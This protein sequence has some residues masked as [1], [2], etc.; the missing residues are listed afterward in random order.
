M[1][2]GAK[3]QANIVGWIKTVMKACKL[4]WSVISD[5]WNACFFF[6]G[7][8]GEDYSVAKRLFSVY[9]SWLIH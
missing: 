2:E 8:K 4:N 1:T 7:G 5:Q 3:P 9:I 6:F